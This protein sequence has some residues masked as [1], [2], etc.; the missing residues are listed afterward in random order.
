[1]PNPGFKQAESFHFRHAAMGKSHNHAGI[2]LDHV[3]PP[4]VTSKMS[5]KRILTVALLCIGALSLGDALSHGGVASDV[6]KLSA[7]N[8]ADFLDASNVSMVQFYAP[9]CGYCKAMAPAFEAA[10]TKLKPSNILLGKVD[11]TTEQRLCR[12][13]EVAAYPTL[14][15]FKNQRPSVKYRGQRNANAIVKFMNQTAAANDG[16]RRFY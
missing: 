11:C 4:N 7:D 14:Q 16:V 15:V 10:A 3:A 5:A 13:Y 2:T 12:E 6:H 9:W 1:M 8:F